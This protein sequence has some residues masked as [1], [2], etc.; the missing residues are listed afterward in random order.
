VY[1]S[2]VMNLITN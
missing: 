1:S 2:A